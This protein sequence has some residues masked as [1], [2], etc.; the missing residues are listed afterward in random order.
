MNL[1]RQR[2]FWYLDSDSLHK[3]SSQ[4][5]TSWKVGQ[6]VW[7][8]HAIGRAGCAQHANRRVYPAAYSPHMDDQIS[9]PG[10]R[11]PPPSG[12]YSPITTSMM[13]DDDI[14]RWAHSK[15]Q[16]CVLLSM[17]VCVTISMFIG[18]KGNTSTVGSFSASVS[19]MV[20]Q[21]ITGR[22]RPLWAPLLLNHAVKSTCSLR[23][24]VM[25]NET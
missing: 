1:N 6:W 15:W 20:K 10:Y 5:L 24:Q 17:F 22:M 4:A 25:L 7:L 13:G 14:T 2:S 8:W 23:T 19:L 11:T 21:L 18:I 3:V 12:Q 9:P 16:L